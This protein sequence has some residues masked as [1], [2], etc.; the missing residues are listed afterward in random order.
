MLP[1]IHFEEGVKFKPKEDE[2]S[3]SGPG[4]KNSPSTTGDAGQ[5]P[6][7]VAE[8][9]HAMWPLSGCCNCR[10]CTPQPLEPGAGAWAATKDSTCCN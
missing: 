9:P 2:P 4:V 5:I 6:G 7:W 10:A 3:L 1:L 8:I